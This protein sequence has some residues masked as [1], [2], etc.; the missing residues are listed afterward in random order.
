L[1]RVDE[2]QQQ[3]QQQQQAKSAQRNTP[4]GLW[5]WR[6]L[7]MEMMIIWIEPNLKDNDKYS[8]T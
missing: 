4:W 8:T 6:L 3:Q 5:Q 7:T 2:K 1:E